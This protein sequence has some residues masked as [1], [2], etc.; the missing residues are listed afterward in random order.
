MAIVAT[1]GINN[2]T[3]KS[4][5]FTAL[6][7][8]TTLTFNH[9]FGATPDFYCITSTLTASTTAGLN[10]WTVSLASSTQFTVTKTAAA[11]SGGSV[12]G[13]SPVAKLIAML[14]SSAMQG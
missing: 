8:D 9:G 3:Y 5:S 6:D 2:P 7:A 14:P 13:T 12:P 10:I 11:G 1:V 4:W